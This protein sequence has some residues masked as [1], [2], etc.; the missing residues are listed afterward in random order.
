MYPFKDGDSF[1]T[2]RNIV[3][4]VTKEINEL[5][6]EYVLKASEAELEDYFIDK[7]SIQPLVLHLDQRYIKRKTGTQIDVSH[8]FRRAIFPG[9]RHVV[10]GTTIDIAIPFE[11]DSMLWSVR[12]S[13]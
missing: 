3:N 11:G 2:F 10:R 5:N 4:S 9:N 8:D 12:A 6:N 13:T 1:A 7:V